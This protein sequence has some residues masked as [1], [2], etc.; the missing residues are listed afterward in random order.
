MNFRFAFVLKSAFAGLALLQLAGCV[1]P[2]PN[3]EGI[4]QV[5]VEESGVRVL[6]NG[7]TLCVV[8]PKLPKVEQWK[9]VENGNAIVVKS[10]AQP[11]GLAAVELFDT[12]TG[13]LKER[14]MSYA[15]YT[16]RPT[17]AEGFQD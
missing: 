12:N 1:S 15:F 10:R 4:V 8:H 6:R 17:W 16:G 7:K 9:L 11:E 13:A 2:P 3:P 5:W 14:L